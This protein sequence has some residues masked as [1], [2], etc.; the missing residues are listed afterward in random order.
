MKLHD[1][2]MTEFIAI[3]SMQITSLLTLRYALLLA[4]GVEPIRA[5]ALAL[6]NNQVWIDDAHIELQ[7][8]GFIKS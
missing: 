4:D 2:P 3:Y 1:L 6:D 5:Q 7:R 8:I